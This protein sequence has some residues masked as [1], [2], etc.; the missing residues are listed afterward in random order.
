MTVMHLGFKIDFE[1]M[2]VQLFQNKHD[3]VIKV[4]T[5]L[6]HKSS[7]TL[8][9]IDELLDFL[10]HYYQIILLDQSFLYISFSFHHI[11]EKRH[12]FSRIYI[13]SKVK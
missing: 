7:I 4:I 2:K 1:A 6:T 5:I 13:S 11:V 3:R 12:K 9:Q 8:K 10:S